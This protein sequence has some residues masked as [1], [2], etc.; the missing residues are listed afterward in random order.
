[1]R[2]IPFLGLGALIGV[3]IIDRARGLGGDLWLDE[4]RSL[5]LA[6]GL[7]AWWQVFFQLL[8]DNNHPLNSLW[9]YAVGPNQS[10]W[11]YRLLSFV[12]GG[13][14]V[15]AAMWAGYSGAKMLSIDALTRRREAASGIGGLL[16]ASCYLF[17]LYATEARGYAGAVCCTLVAMGALLSAPLD[18]KSWGHLTAYWAACGVGVVSH[19]VFLPVIVAGPIWTVGKLWE[20][21][22]SRRDMLRAVASWHV[23]PLLFSVAYFFLFLNRIVVSGGQSETVAGTIHHLACFVL[24]LPEATPQWLGLFLLGFA[25]VGCLGFLATKSRPL[26]FYY[27]ALIVVLPA[28]IFL[29]SK[30]HIIFPRYFIVSA[31]CLAVALA[32]TLAYL[33]RGRVSTAIVTACVVGIVVGNA[34]HFEKLVLLGR[35]AQR[36]CFKYVV[37]HTPATSAITLAGEHDGRVLEAV[38]YYFPKVAAGREVRYMTHEN[39]RKNGAQWFLVYYFKDS[40]ALPAELRDEA[41]NVWHREASWEHAPLSGGDWL[42]YRNR[43]YR[44]N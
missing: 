14:A 34:V 23:L 15:I 33:M 6:G 4:L 26:A 41:G 24:G 37:D 8:E 27:G 7:K 30:Q 17:S 36:E 9:L 38:S 20:R 25:V 11:C 21:N 3:L 35:G 42:V 39:W 5:H 16:L 31:A 28:L 19:A 10:E 12:A 43:D 13:G 44:S 32:Q 40:R 1:M 18:K 29:L 2:R 22:S